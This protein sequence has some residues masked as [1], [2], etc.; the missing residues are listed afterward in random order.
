MPLETVTM[1]RHCNHVAN[2]GFAI[3][4][5]HSVLN[6]ELGKTR[7]CPLRTHSSHTFYINLSLYR[8]DP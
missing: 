3:V 6:F 4:Y 2:V 7:P 8:Y 5:L 1:I